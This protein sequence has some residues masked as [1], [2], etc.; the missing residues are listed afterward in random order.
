MKAMLNK[1]ICF[2]CFLCFTSSVCAQLST[3]SVISSDMVL[4]QG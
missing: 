4:Q 1:W 3:P 2:I